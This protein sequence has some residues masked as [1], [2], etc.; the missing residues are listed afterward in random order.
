MAYKEVGS[1]E[2]GGDSTVKER[3]RTHGILFGK[4]GLVGES[5]SFSSISQRENAEIA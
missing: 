1:G 4:N 3:G 2:G 5:S